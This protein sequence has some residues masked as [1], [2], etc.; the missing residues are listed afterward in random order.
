MRESLGSTT[1]Q[2]VCHCLPAPAVAVSPEP[3]L[4]ATEAIF[5]AQQRLNKFKSKTN[6]CDMIFYSLLE[7]TIP[8]G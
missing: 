7:N 2:V 6:L 3:T 4:L 8:E 5:A 1:K